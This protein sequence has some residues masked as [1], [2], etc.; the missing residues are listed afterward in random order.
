MLGESREGR[1]PYRQTERSERVRAATRDKILRAARKL[2]VQRGFAATSMD[3]IVKLA[4]TSIGNLYFYFANKE[5]LL[6]TLAEMSLRAAWARGDELMAA[7]PA[8]PARVAAMVYANA[9]GLMVK[10]RDILKIMLAAERLLPVRDH[11]VELNMARVRG[12]LKENIPDY[13]ARDLDLVAIAWSGA[14]RYLF[15]QGLGNSRLNGSPSRLAE[16]TVRWN[17]RALQVPERDIDK[18]V[19]TAERALAAHTAREKK[20]VRDGKR[21]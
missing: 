12:I 7:V 20:T 4:G 15:E 16:Y 9:Y 5:A 10:D 2:F 11:I 19:A 18:A 1:V 21:R 17:L 8:G 3:A 14:A 13:M 6:G